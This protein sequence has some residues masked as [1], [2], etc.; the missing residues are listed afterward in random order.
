M[1]KDEKG[2]NDDDGNKDKSSAYANSGCSARGQ[3]M[4]DSFI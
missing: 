3:A 1:A 4:T 2:Q